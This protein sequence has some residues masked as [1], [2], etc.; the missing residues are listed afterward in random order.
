MVTTDISSSEYASQVRQVMTVARKLRDIGAQVV[1]DIP[2]IAVIGGQSAGK[3]SLVEGVTGIR[4]PRAAGTCTRCPMEVNLKSGTGPWSC[5]ITLRFEYNQEGQPLPEVFLIPFGAPLTS[6][7]DVEIALMRAQAAILNYPRI[8]HNDFLTKSKS[9]L[10][11]YRTNDAFDNGTLKF[12]KN[13]VCVDV[14]DEG[15]PD[16][17]FVDL[18]GL[19][20]N[21][22]RELV[23]LV[24]DLVR[25]NITGECLIL[26][27]IPMSDDMENQRAMR[28]AREVDSE[29]RRTIGVLTKPDTLT[30][31]ATSAHQKWKDV[32][33]GKEH[34]LMLGYYC[35]KLSDDVERASNLSRAQRNDAERTFFEAKSPWTELQ[36]NPTLRKRFG[37]GNTVADLSTQLSRLLELALPGLRTKAEQLLAECKSMLAELPRPIAVDAST[38]ILTRVTDFCQHLTATV[39]GLDCVTSEDSVSATDG[40]TFVQQNRATYL[41]FKRRIRSTAPDFRPFEDHKRYITPSNP[42]D[43]DDDE[44]FYPMISEAPQN[45][46][47]HNLYDVHRVIKS[48]IAWELP[49]NTP[50]DAKRHLINQFTCLWDAPALECFNAVASR[51][52]LNLRA[53]V[54]RHF[55]RFPKLQGYMFMKIMELLSRQEAS[56]AVAVEMALK[57]EKDPLFTQNTHYLESCRE[58]WL[59]HYKS[60][61]NNQDQFL[62]TRQVPAP[63]YETGEVETAEEGYEGPRVV[64]PFAPRQRS[65]T[66]TAAERAL[67]ALAELG[68]RNLSEKDLARLHKAPDNFQEEL[69]VMADV[70]A[71]FQ[72]AYKRIID[73]IPLTIEHSLNKG[74]AK[75]MKTSLLQQL[76]LDSS[77]ASKRLKDLL[78]EDPN[79]KTRREQLETRRR[80]LEQVLLE[81]QKVGV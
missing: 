57:L 79:V 26:V 33:S 9:E 29:R 73:H 21:D 54:K 14:F 30:K 69:M 2:R 67:S 50:F 10:E 68:Y 76:D 16:L 34:P 11:V 13:V 17:S 32:L 55:H 28:L 38:E 8:Q 78:D 43:S 31:G 48:S 63:Q 72:V 39:N 51:L 66:I 58:K 65:L 75:S 23:D 77:E 4:V 44:N 19:I 35:V 1:L 81:L 70:R 25:S 24:E 62:S 64:H 46:G 49:N 59:S 20:Q 53:S 56:S 52:R 45:Q 74:L 42:D 60:V 18:P 47:P 12:S 40:K 22:E 6:P 61:R 36:A 80:R 41:Q 37:V 5:E 15:C 3:S 27:A 71:Y 7:D